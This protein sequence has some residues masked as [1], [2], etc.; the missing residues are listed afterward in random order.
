MEFKH[1]G[2]C[3]TKPDVLIKYSKVDKVHSRNCQNKIF[4]CMKSYFHVSV[5]INF[6][7]LNKILL[8]EF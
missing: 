4:F 1:P 6:K 8:E 7:S 3:F 5:S 2:K